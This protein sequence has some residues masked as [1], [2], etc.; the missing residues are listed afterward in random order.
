MSRIQEA[1][2]QA[3]QL[4]TEAI[5]GEEPN[6]IARIADYD[7]TLLGMLREVGQG[8]LAD[9]ATATVKQEEMKQRS[10]GFTVE[11]RNE[12]LFLPSSGLSKSARRTCG[13]ERPSK[14]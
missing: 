9:V 3:R 11:A 2:K 6:L 1:Q 14:V 10:A 12:S 4:L 7:T 13:I 8:V 5:L